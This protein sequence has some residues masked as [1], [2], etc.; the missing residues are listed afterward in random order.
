MLSSLNAVISTN[1][2]TQIITCNV[3]YYSAYT[4]K[5]QLKTTMF[6]FSLHI[7]PVVCQWR[8]KLTAFPAKVCPY[9]RSK[10][11]NT[12][13]FV[14]LPGNCS[15]NSL[16]LRQAH[17]GT[18]FIW[19]SECFHHACTISLSAAFL[20]SCVLKVK[21]RNLIFRNFFIHLAIVQNWTFHFSPSSSCQLYSSCPGWF[22]AWFLS[23]ISHKKYQMESKVV[24]T[25]MMEIL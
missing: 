4:Y 18:T 6:Y 23:N 21:R 14:F 13:N 9:L 17:W 20:W 7:Y 24:W 1:E 15:G 8:T 25:P 5:F 16:G 2:S 22:N 12:V 10:A 3:M 19:Y 11:E